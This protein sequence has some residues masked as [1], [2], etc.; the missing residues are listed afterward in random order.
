MPDRLSASRR[1]ASTSE[2]DAEQQG[3]ARRRREHVVRGLTHVDV[4]VRVH[5]RVLAPRLAG[6]L[7]R[8]VGKHL[9][10]VHVVRRAGSRLVDVD[11]EL[12][13]KPAGKYLVGGGD[14]EARELRFEPSE[15]GVRF[16]G[17]LL[18]E[19]RGGDEIRLRAQAADR[20]ILDRAH[21]LHAVVGV[22][23]NLQLA[24]RVGFGAELHQSQ[25]AQRLEAREAK[26]R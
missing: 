8:A 22:G 4:I 6:D 25:E 13:A 14:D 2:R 12:I 16:G 21:R 3:Q 19:N 26:S 7:G 20:E 1:A 5:A 11:H 17:R 9:V 23:R 18:D 10:G 15:R 24:E